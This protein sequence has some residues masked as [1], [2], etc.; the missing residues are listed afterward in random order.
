MYKE[1]KVENIEVLIASGY[2]REAIINFKEIVD[3]QLLKHPQSEAYKELLNSTILLSAK[4]HNLMKGEINGNIDQNYISIERTKLSNSLLKM[5]Q[6]FVD[7]DSR[8]QKIKN[9][10]NIGGNTT[11]NEN[12]CFETKTI[13]ITIDENFDTY[14]DED[15]IKLIKAIEHLLGMEGDLKI[16]K[17]RKGSVILSIDIPVDKYDMLINSFKEGYFDKFNIVKID[18]ETRNKPVISDN[19]K[20]ISNKELKDKISLDEPAPENRRI[21]KGGG[22]NIFVSRLS[23]ETSEENLRS[24]FEQFGEVGALAIIRDKA[25]GISKGFGFVEMTNSDEASAAINALNGSE[26]DHTT[27]FV[28]SGDSQKRDISHKKANDIRG[29]FGNDDTS[30]FN[31]R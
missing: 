16:R 18:E 8:F 11:D 10:V 27:I 9:K 20:S 15:K 28:S 7:I 6:T 5:S 22:I 26:F 14:S 17:I 21:S 29:K 25:T 24:L 30:N 3:A 2:I 13:E 19:Y 23:Y 1:S 4:Y 31:K 12:A